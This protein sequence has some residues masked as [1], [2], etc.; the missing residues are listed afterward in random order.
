MTVRAALLGLLGAAAIC[1]FTYLND[2]IMG[3]TY[4]VGNN[5]PIS[6]YGTLVLFVLLAN[7]LLAWLHR[8]LALSGKELALILAL[9]LAA[10]CVPGSG[11]MRTFSSSVIM[12]HH[13]AKIAPGW[14][15][16]KVIEMV[17][18]GLLVDV[19][20]D[21]E[22]VLQGFLKGR[23]AEADGAPSRGVPWRA[24]ARP[25]RFWLPLVLALWVGLTGLSLAVHRQWAHHE[26]LPYP[27]ASFANRL[28]PE[29]GQTTSSVFRNRLFWIG[30]GAVLAV[31]LI[32]YGATWSDKMISIPMG[33]NFLSLTELFPAMRRGGVWGLFNP[34]VYVTVVAFAYFLAADVSLSLGLSA[35]AYSLLTGVLAGYGITTRG[36]GGTFAPNI[37]NFLMF[38]A[39]LGMLGSMLYTGRQYYAAVARRALC[40][41][42]PG[43]AP[44]DA[45]WGGRIF[46]AGMLAFFSMLLSLGLD[47]QLALLYSGGVVLTFLVMARI[48]AETG[49]FFIQAYWFPCAAL[50]GLF[51]ARALGP[52][53]ML[54]LFLLSMVLLVDPREALMPFMINSLKVLDLRGHKLGRSVA[55]CIVALLLGMAIAVPA[56][57]GL[58]YRNGIPWHDQWASR[59]VPQAPFNEVV[60]ASQQLQAQ[61]S[62]EA[63]SEVRGWARFR[64]AAP[65]APLVFSGLAG[66]L[67]VLLFAAGRLRFPK[68]PLHPVLFLVWA[69][70]PARLFAFS[71]L[72]GWLLKVLMTKY[73]G[74]RAYQR[75]KPLM[76]GLIAGEMLGGFI[77]ALIGWIYCYLTG[78]MP[79]PYRVMPG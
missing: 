74:A 59:S 1:G 35:Y 42:S 67:L 17:P 56:T 29:K 77:P 40:L 8:P 23:G 66:M 39:Y 5:M 36:G 73:G 54:I 7:P 72:L 46:L 25:L 44:E 60:K 6:V 69:T 18:D 48:L 61:G 76:F 19:S 30:A 53:T 57:L 75:F 51:G 26:H 20:K 38:G 37:R 24:W 14:Q 3:Q 52:E 70:Y 4:L 27:I 28:L 2:A 55:L 34:R 31:H 71:F 78:E 68:W 16:H 43:K 79:Q 9:V 63:A 47:W 45:V 21:E 32:N 41:P 33:L 50:A 49:L 15:E 65:R 12:P 62:L 22:A 58:Q 10:C 13:W 64:N 11:L